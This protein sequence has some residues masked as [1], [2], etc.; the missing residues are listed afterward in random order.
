MSTCF[1][2]LNAT[3]LD[4]RRFDTLEQALAGVDDMVGEHDH[5]SIGESSGNDGCGR[6]VGYGR[7][8]IQVGLS[9][10]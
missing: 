2:L 7:G 8:P 5:W 4:E 10:Y 6:R 1:I 9:F 3:V